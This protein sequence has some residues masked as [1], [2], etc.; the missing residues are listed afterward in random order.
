MPYFEKHVFL[1]TNRRDPGNPKGSCA[2][3]DS[4]AVRGRFKKEIAERGR[5]GLRRC[6]DRIEL[7]ELALYLR[8]DFVLMIVV[9]GHRRVDFSKL[10]VGIVS[11]DFFRTEP[12]GSIVH[13]NH[14]DASARIVL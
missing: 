3:K 2:A 5:T 7:I 14:R 1:C 10:Q 9:I 12:A 13:H 8:I 4:E 11:R 6:Q